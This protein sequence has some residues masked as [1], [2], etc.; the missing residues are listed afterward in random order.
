V[1]DAT[2]GKNK[3]GGAQVT[4]AKDGV[5]TTVTTNAQGRYSINVKAGEYTV[6]ASKADWIDRTKTLEV[7]HSI[8]RGQGADLAM[9]GVLPPGGFRV[10]LNWAA[11][12][13]DLDS[14]TYFDSNFKKF[15]YYGRPRMTGP[16]S[17]ISV[18]L[19]R[20]D[21]NGHGP[22]T[23]T[24]LGLG[25]CTDSCLVKFH[26]DNYSWRDAHLGDSEGVVTVYEGD[27]VKATYN[28]PSDIG[29]KRGWTVF[30]LDASNLEIYEGD[31]VYAPF[32]KK[33]HGMSG[34][35]KWQDSMDYEGWSKV[36]VG[37]VLFGMSANKVGKGL[38]NLG[39]AYYYTVQNVRAPKPTITQVD[40]TGILEAGETAMCPEGSWVSAI[41]REGG[42]AV[43][44]NGP[45]QITK[46]ECSSFEGVTEWGE[47]VGTDSFE[48]GG[49]KAARCPNIDGAATAMV[50]FHHTGQK[51]KEGNSK[52]KHLDVIK[53]CAFPKKLVPEPE[54][55]LCIA[56][57]TCTGLMGKQ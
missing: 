38:Q 1:T 45:H 53:C 15:I 12:S 44:P 9:S 28:I 48:E 8:Q 2:N 40:W 23:S 6:T 21:V 10:V 29:D 16:N 34:Q 30:T 13:K 26:V 41:Y 31:R 17:G 18:S 56:T 22:E 49:A 19:D 36:P 20:D 55:K 27:G 50:G 57:Q 51:N 32:I 35:T 52:L 4:F 54:S 25:H 37:S 39:I 46:A 7:E 42:K 5:S 24:Y 43:P 33:A 47:C 3:I 14:W 11:H